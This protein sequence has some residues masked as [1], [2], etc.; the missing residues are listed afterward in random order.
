MGFLGERTIK[1]LCSGSKAGTIQSLN[2][3][4]YINCKINFA[5][6]WISYE[7]LAFSQCVAKRGRNCLIFKCRIFWNLLSINAIIVLAVRVTIILILAS[8]QDLGGACGNRRS[9]TMLIVKPNEDYQDLFEECKTEIQNLP[10][11]I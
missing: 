5:P 3:S 11:P 9:M 4:L 7:I 8:F 2:I 1:D 10:M 6:L